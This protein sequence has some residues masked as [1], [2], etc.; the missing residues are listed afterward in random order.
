MSIIVVFASLIALEVVVLVSFVIDLRAGRMIALLAGPLID[1]PLGT[2]V[3]VLADVTANAWAASMTALEFIP[4]L[5]SSEEAL[6]S[7]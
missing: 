5:E 3:D 4:T 1:V 2:G 6:S 7:C